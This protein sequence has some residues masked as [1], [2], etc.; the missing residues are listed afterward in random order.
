VRRRSGGRAAPLLGGVHPARSAPAGAARSSR[1]T[2]TRHTERSKPSPTGVGWP[3]CSTSPWWRPGKRW[4]RPRRSPVRRVG[5]LA[6]PFHRLTGT[7]MATRGLLSCHRHQGLRS[8]PHT[9]PRTR[10]VSPKAGREGLAV[11]P[12]HHYLLHG[13]FM[14]AAPR[15][16]PLPP[17]ETPA[18]RFGSRHPTD[19]PAEVITLGDS[20]PRTRDG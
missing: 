7:V 14:G 6:T 13:P 9:P 5:V 11:G 17:R 4:Q 2:R 19:S 20:G 1:P 18:P 8:R 12:Q 3:P 15:S 16:D 10:A